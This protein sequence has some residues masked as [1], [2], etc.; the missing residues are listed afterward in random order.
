MSIIK[1]GLSSQNVSISKS[2]NL[3]SPSSKPLVG[4]VYG[5]V[6]TENTPSKELFEKAGGFSGIGTVF[7]RTYNTSKEIQETIDLTSP[8]AQAIPLNPQI[9]SI[10]LLGELIYLID[11]PSPVSQ[12]SKNKSTT[13]AQKYYTNINVWNNTQQNSLP[14]S[15]RSSL[16]LT[17]SENPTIKP[18][19]PFEGDYIVQ[20]R[21]GNALRFSTTTKLYNNLNEWSDVGNDQ[22]PITILSNGFA[23]DP[24]EK[25]HVEK[26]NKDASSLYLTST[27]QIPLQTDKTGN[28]NPLTKPIDVSKY[29]NSQ[30]ILNSDRVVLNS[31][32]DEVMIF[33]KSNIELNTK[34][35]INLNADERIHFNS[36]TVFLGTVNNSLPTEP[37]VLGDKLNTILENL[38]DSLYSF[39]AALSSVVGSP[40]G[41][42]AMDI[43]MAAEGL[44][45]DIDRINDNL[46]GILSQQNFTA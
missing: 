28:L 16:G 23:Y 11:L 42:P 34:N 44:L 24:K 32:R 12:F 43:N 36:N 17:F 26:I 18:L 27:Q 15:D 45:N 35:I 1:T 5:V 37:L 19:L 6:T 25:Y 41:A 13:A 46:E 3:P 2:R 21:Q 10:P 9:Q 20:G 8:L 40:E 4:K 14:T 33:A 31:K 38:L 7:Y 29:F 22:D 30:L 39:G